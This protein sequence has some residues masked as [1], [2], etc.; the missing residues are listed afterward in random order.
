[1]SAGRWTMSSNWAILLAIQLL[2]LACDGGG[3]GPVADATATD[4]VAGDAGSGPL[5][6]NPVTRRLWV[7]DTVKFTRQDPVGIA[8]GWNLD[9]KVSDEKDDASCGKPD[10]KSPAGV[11]GIDNQFAV[12]VPIIEKTGIAAF[13]SLLQASVE[14]GGVLLMVELEGI[15]DLRNDPEV[16]V[17]I[18]AGQGVP[19]LGTDGKVLT[20]QTFHVNK[21][22][23][24]TPCGKGALKDGVVDIGPFDIDL[25]IQVFG[26]EY[27]LEMRTGHVRF[28]VIDAQRIDGG[29]VGGGI[30][31]SS[32]GKI[33]KT[34]AE[35]QGNIDD[36]VQSLT[37]GMGDLAKDATGTCTQLSAVL[38]FSGVSAFFYPYEITQTTKN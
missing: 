11:D 34:A 18:R 9:G 3:A 36:I 30:T 17:T 20:G 21:R 35:D 26:K 1:M 4:A 7:L 29:L 12:L 33:A 32:I 19:L 22:D 6:R 37:G 2:L 14:S 13:E 15:D 16:K 31:L 27:T 10:F 5:A 25:P 28:H 8:P 24:A 38:S 23:P